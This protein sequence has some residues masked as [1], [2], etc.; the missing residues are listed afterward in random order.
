MHGCHDFINED[1]KAGTGWI[2]WKKC[3]G[4][5]CDRRM[6]AKLKGKDIQNSD[7]RVALL[8]PMGHKRGLQRN[9]NEETRKTD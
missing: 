7:H 6:P 9:C 8:G 2:N 1:H 4:V 5:L 3:S